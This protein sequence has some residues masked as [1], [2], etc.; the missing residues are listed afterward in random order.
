MFDF[1]YLLILLSLIPA[2]AIPL[3]IRLIPHEPK[4]HTISLEAK[5]YGYSPGRI[6]VNKG[7]TVI[8]KPTSLDVTHGFLLDG[9]SIDAILK[10]Q[11]LTFLKYQWKD[12]DNNIQ[13]DWDKVKEIK[14]KAEKAGNGIVYLSF[15]CTSKDRF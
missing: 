10:Q 12:D 13:T 14:F 11:G 8:L 9:Y 5:K 4:V 7:D 6:V 3:L 15:P 2:L 1:T